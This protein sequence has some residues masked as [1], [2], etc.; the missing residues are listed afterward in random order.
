MAEKQPNKAM[1]N[2][3]Q[4]LFKKIFAGKNKPKE[5]ELNKSIIKRIFVEYVVPNKWYFIFSAIFSSI[6]GAM[7]VGMVSQ[8]EPV[9]N[10]VFISKNGAVLFRTAGLVILIFLTRGISTYIY[11]LLIGIAGAKMIKD[12]QIRLSSKLLYQSQAFFNQNRSGQLQARFQ[13]DTAQIQSVTRDLVAS[14]SNIVSV[15]GLTCYMVYKDPV[16]ASFVLVIV[17][18]AILPLRNL[19]RK[20]KHLAQNFQLE[21]GFLLEIVGQTM[22]S[23]RV[24]QAYTQEEYEHKKISQSA[25]SLRQLS[26]KRL[27]LTGITSPLMETLGGLAAAAIIIYGGYQV[28]WGNKLPGAFVA[29]IASFIAAY[30]PAKKLGRVPVAL[31]FG[32]VAA[33]R[34]YTLIDQAITIKDKPNATELKVN[35]GELVFDHVTFSYHDTPDQTIREEHQIIEERRGKKEENDNKSRIP[36]VIKDI[37]FDAPAGKTVALVGQSGSG[38]STIMNLILRFWDVSS[39]S[40]KIDGQDIRNVTLKSLRDHM[41]FVNQEVTLFDTTVEQ[42]IR[43]GRDDATKEEIIEA[44]KNAAAHDFIMALPQQYNTVIGEQGILLSGG[45]RQRLAIAR[46]MVRNAPI[47]LLDE[48][49]S[50]LD[51]E[52]ERAVQGALERLME[53]KTAIV[54]AHRLSTI[55]NADTIYVMKDGQIMERGNHRELITQGGYYKQLYDMQF[56]EET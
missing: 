42:N 25:E 45:Q 50:A 47:L 48:A 41:A 3:R 7:S 9:I 49:T 8:L 33:G 21:G 16:L 24:V 14:I 40:V 52:S 35:K 15:I 53:G 54:I 51:T 38:K 22:R 11:Q 26:I 10:E 34:I 12:M 13:N 5:A 46:A 18:I 44:A 37:S 19:S 28:I 6:A 39:G 23:S 17:P 27:K 1:P 56:Q 4:G 43:Y 31:Q 32:L 29:F 30:E 55:V 20:M 36:S 2:K